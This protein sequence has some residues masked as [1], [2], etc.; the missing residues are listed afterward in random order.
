MSGIDELMGLADDYADWA[1]SK[2]REHPGTLEVAAKLKSELTDL[3]REAARWRA[4]KS[5]GTLGFQAAPGWDA[6]VRVPMVDAENATLD[7]IIDA[8]MKQNGE[9]NE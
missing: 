3:C 7:A 6:V 1:E 8:A 2:G 9:A 5:L 4:L